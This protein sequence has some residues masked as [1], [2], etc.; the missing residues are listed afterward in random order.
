[1]DAATQTLFDAGNA[2][3]TLV[4]ARL[5]EAA[6][7]VVMSDDDGWDANTEATL[8]AMH[9]GVP[10]IVNGRLPRAGAMVGAPDLLVLMG[11]GYVP[12]DVKLHGTRQDSARRAVWVSSLAEPSRRWK[13]VG[14][15]DATRSMEDD[16]LQLAHYTRM[17]QA[18]GLHAGDDYVMGGIIGSSDYSD[19][20]GDP[21][22]VVWYELNA[23]RKD[24][25]SAST[26]SGRAKRSLLERYDHE[27]AFRLQVA[28]TARAGDEIVRPFHVTECARCVWEE[29][30]VQ[31]AG[32][33]DA[34]FAIR[35]GLPTAQQWRYLYDLG[36]TTVADLATAGDDPPEPW[37]PRDTQPG[38]R[39]QQKYSALV[40]RARMALSG[41]AFEP[42][43]DW[44]QVPSADVEVDF[45]IE[46]DLEGRIYLWGLRV[47]Q[48][49]DESTAVFDPVLSYAPLDDDGAADLAQEFA[50]RLGRVI[51]EAEAAGKSVTVFH[52]SHPER[53][54][55]SNHPAVHALL[56][57][58]A[59]DLHAWYTKHFFPRDGASIKVV[60]PI[61]GFRW[62]VDD[63]GGAESQVR[64][65]VARGG[66]EDAAA[67]IE[68]LSR[69]NESDVAAQAAI[70]D[71][72]RRSRPERDA[73]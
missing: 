47:R 51:S 37:S 21:W 29:Y 7:A 55:T 23:P 64:I 73:H 70:R 11:E 19:L 4:N 6:G 22:L 56:E 46:W 66:G 12:V 62:A 1:M 71:G 5:G 65:E 20:G 9:S 36:L 32:P 24:T 35:T 31:V 44:P 10:L 69:Y 43:E 52:W 50:T 3:E 59:L 58:H 39:A 30:C 63:A 16:G 42:H 57:R 38:G 40:R 68:W 18:L 33:E 54:R 34:S 72:L 45:D 41:V 67:A 27:F 8:A 61:F 2:F 13:Q 14:L 49:Q 48:G 17:L 25:F 60:A 28:E 53:S 26:E 15:S